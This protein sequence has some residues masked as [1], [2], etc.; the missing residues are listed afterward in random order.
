[1]ETEETLCNICHTDFEPNDDLV[2]LKCGHVFHYECIYITYKNNIDNAGASDL[3][4]KL[5]GN[6]AIKYLYLNGKNILGNTS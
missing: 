1:M 5:K 3:A 2:K 4:T 6:T